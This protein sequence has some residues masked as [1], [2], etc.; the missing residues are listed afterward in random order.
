MPQKISKRTTAASVSLIALAG[1]ALGATVMATAEAQ[2]NR[3]VTSDRVAPVM[4]PS[5]ADLIEHVS[6]AVVS[7]EVTTE[8]SGGVAGLTPDAL[9]PG[10]EEFLERFGQA[11]PEQQPRQAQGA[12]SGFFIS[13]DGLVVTNYHVVEN[14]TEISISLKDGRELDAEIVGTDE[15]TDLALLRVE[16]DE[17]PFVQFDTDPHY[18][19]GDWVVAVGNPFGLGGTATAGIISAIGREEPN[20]RYNGFIQIDAP[21]N[22]GNSGGPTFDI[23]GNVIGVN[24]QIFSPTGGN[25]GIGFAIPSDV[26]ANIIDQLAESGSVTRGWLGVTIQNV[27]EELADAFEVEADTGAVVASVNAG[28]PADDAGFE[29]G[30]IVLAI[31]G[32]EVDSA[33]DLTRQVGSLRAGETYRFDILRGGDRRALNVTI[34]IRP[35]EDQLLAEATPDTPSSPASA[36]TSEFGLSL[37]PLTDATR[38]ELGVADDVRGVA[39]VDVDADSEA[40]QRGFAPGFVITQVDGR[41]V[42]TPQD[43]NDA[44]ER[45]RSSGKSAAALLVNTSRGTTFVALPLQESDAG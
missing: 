6:P 26:A 35:P 30:D 15:P 9:P 13:S 37:A 20:A 44:I 34:G 10:F 38:S 43:F 7:V 21:I 8:V 39:V 2:D 41:R 29:S 11:V 17:F 27:T 32:D 14:A 45:A 1:A 31:D 42:N 40:A 5:F 23:N 16:G 18:R 24:S 33:T 4:A 12:G 25:I 19:V 22:R 28:S 36:E 3:S